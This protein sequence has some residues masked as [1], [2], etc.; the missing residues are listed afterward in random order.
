[1]SC[2]KHTNNFLTLICSIRNLKFLYGLKALHILTALTLTNSPQPLRGCSNITSCMEPSQKFLVLEINGS[3]LF[4]SYS[5]TSNFWLL[6]HCILSIYST[7]L[8]QDS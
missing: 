5:I 7:I 6:A 2:N 8:F 3:L 1:M 4:L